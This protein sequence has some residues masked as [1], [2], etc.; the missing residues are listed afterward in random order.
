MT[1]NEWYVDH[2]LT[3]SVTKVKVLKN[4]WERLEDDGWDSE[5]LVGIFD[6]FLESVALD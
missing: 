2:D 6:Q 3:Y 1:L 5:T 4:L